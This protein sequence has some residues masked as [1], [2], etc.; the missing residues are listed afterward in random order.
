MT[1]VAKRRRRQAANMRLNKRARRT[2]P[3]GTKR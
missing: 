3:K 1:S 2:L